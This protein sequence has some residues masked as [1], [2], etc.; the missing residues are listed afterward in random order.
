MSTHRIALGFALASA[1]LVACAHPS[2]AVSPAQSVETTGAV[3]PIDPQSMAQDADGLCD[4]VVEAPVVVPRP[5]DE[6]DHHARAVANANQVIEDLTPD[7]LACYKARVAKD[8]RAHGFITTDIVVGPDGHV[9]RVETTGGAVLGPATMGC[10]V[11]R[12]ERATFEPPHGGGTQHIMIPW[13]LRR[14]EPGELP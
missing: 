2:P 3:V 14:V 1:A 5:A 10:I 9:L 11:H 7:L 4:L 8:P 12:I 6:P 13:N